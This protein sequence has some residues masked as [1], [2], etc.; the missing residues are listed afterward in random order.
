MDAELLELEVAEDLLMHDLPGTR[1]VLSE[2][3]ALGVRIVVDQ[4]GVG[5]SS[6]TRLERLPLDA[7]KI[8][9]SFVHQVSEASAG[10]TDAVV[11]LGRTLSLT[12]VGQGVETDEQATFLRDHGCDELQGFHVHRPMRPQELEEV[13][14]EHH[15]DDDPGAALGGSGA[16]KPAA[17]R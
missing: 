6:L 11:A 14:R 4:F 10:F 16:S 15:R 8:D 7:I 5:Y 3:K 2:L 12:V 17:V 13:L 1:R 9:G